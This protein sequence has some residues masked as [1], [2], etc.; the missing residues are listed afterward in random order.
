MSHFSLMWPLLSYEAAFLATVI[1]TVIGVLR[2]STK[3]LT[4]AEK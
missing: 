1:F 4:T 2:L 3:K